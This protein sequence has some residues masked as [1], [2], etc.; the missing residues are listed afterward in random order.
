MVTTALR[1]REGIALNH[2]QEKY[3]DYLLKQAKNHLKYGLLTFKDDSI[4][5]TKKGLFVSDSVMSD[6]MFV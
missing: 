1:T 6:L 5:L 4:A 3:Q 2:L